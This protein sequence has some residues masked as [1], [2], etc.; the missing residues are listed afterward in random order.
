MFFLIIRRAVVTGSN[1]GIGFGTVTLLA[2]EGVKVVLT[3]LDEKRGL[4]A[5]EK[6]KDYGF[7]D[8]VVYHQLDVTDPIALLSLPILSKPNLGNSISCTYDVNN[9]GIGG[10]FVDP[11]A[12]KAA[13]AAGMAEE[14]VKIN[15][16][17]AKK[18]TEA[19]L[20]LLQLSDSPR[21]SNITSGGGQFMI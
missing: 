1:Q 19:F 9:A 21:V 5:I 3:A 10:T 11:E 6:L 16:Y 8:L 12:F 2:S 18:M 17:G 15:Y 4:E 13:A 7:S 14:C 20:P